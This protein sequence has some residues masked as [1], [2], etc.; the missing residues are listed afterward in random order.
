MRLA[1]RNGYLDRDWG[2]RVGTVERRIPKLHKSRY[3]QSFLEP[4]RTVAKAPTAAIPEA[5]IP[6]SSVSPGLRRCA[7]DRAA[8]C[9]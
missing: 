6:G 4:R 3:F 1:Q 9:R 8:A 5:Y 2:L 7:T